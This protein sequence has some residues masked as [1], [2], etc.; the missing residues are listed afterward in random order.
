[1][2]KWSAFTIVLVVAIHHGVDFHD[3]LQIFQP[4]N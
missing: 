3:V 4:V 1:M 2:W